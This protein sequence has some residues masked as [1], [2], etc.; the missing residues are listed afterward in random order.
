MNEQKL[1]VLNKHQG[2]AVELTTLSAFFNALK[3]SL[4]SITWG[5]V[6]WW[7]V[8][9]R[10]EGRGVVVDCTKGGGNEGEWWLNVPSE[11]GSRG[12]VVDCTK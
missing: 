5:R 4:R 11:A 6:H 2:Q 9:R 1:N 10:A 7:T 3:T 8:P 12:L